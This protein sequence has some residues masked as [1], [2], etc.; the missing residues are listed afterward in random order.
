[1]TSIAV[2]RARARWTR[3]A[4]RANSSDASLLTDAFLSVERRFPPG[5]HSSHLG[6]DV[7][8]RHSGSGSMLLDDF[9]GERNHAIVGARFGV[10]LWR[11]TSGPDMTP[12]CFTPRL[13]PCKRCDTLRG[14]RSAKRSLEGKR[15]SVTRWS[16]HFDGLCCQQVCN[17]VTLRVLRA[18][19]LKLLASSRT[20]V[21]TL[22]A[23]FLGGMPLGGFGFAV[24]V[25]MFVLSALDR[26]P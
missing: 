1:M 8:G 18:S 4:P 14:I 26:Y 2:P 19:Q 10:V 17:W 16:R 3:G 22:L 7:L 21:D 12:S 25:R 24:R 11:G 23:S 5:A 15:R 9:Y 6:D 20:C 13:G